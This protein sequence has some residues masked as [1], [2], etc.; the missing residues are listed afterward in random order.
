ME[1]SKKHDN[2]E[3]IITAMILIFSPFPLYYYL[4]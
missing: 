1:I 3:S 4:I 2:I